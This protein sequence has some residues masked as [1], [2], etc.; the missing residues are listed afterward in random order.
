MVWV[1]SLVL[2]R[3]QIPAWIYRRLLDVQSRFR[4]DAAYRTKLSG[5]E[6]RAHVQFFTRLDQI[7]KTADW[8][9]IYTFEARVSRRDL[10][11]TESGLL[12]P[13]AVS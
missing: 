12:I 7:I 13:G 4:H 2:T 3:S 9:D 8:Q 6:A 1:V 11:R 10:V 5:G